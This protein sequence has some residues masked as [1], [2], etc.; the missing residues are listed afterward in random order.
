MNDIVW[1]IDPK[2]DS[3]DF[4]LLRMKSHAVR[5]FEAKGINYDIEIPPEMSSL[6]LP[7]GYRRRLF[8]IYKEAVNNIIRHAQSTRVTLTIRREDGSLVMTIADDGKG[9]DPEL[10]REG[11]GLRNMEERARSLN[12]T[13]TIRSGRAS[14]TAVTLKAAIP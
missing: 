13:L 3:F 2:N 6:R 5:M 7:L 14:G 9:F 4:L 1:S 8:L 11:N 10:A 12:G